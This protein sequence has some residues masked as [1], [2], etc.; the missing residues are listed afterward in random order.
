MSHLVITDLS[1]NMVAGVSRYSAAH[2][3]H[4]T[5]RSLE[6]LVAMEMLRAAPR[7]WSGATAWITRDDDLPGRYAVGIICNDGFPS[8]AS[9]TTRLYERV[10]RL[11]SFIEVTH[12]S[13]YTDALVATTWVAPRTWQYD[14]RYWKRSSGLPRASRADRTAT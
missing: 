12:G 11:M 1:R 7:F 2:P 6:M 14:S 3:E 8:R 4:A 9:A 10:F 13:D 5:R